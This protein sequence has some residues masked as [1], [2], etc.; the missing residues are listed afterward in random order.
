MPSFLMPFAIFLELS[1][2][3]QAKQWQREASRWKREGDEA[4]L[5]SPSFDAERRGTHCLRYPEPDFDDR[6]STPSGNHT[7]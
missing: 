2:G 4:L 3:R 7:P 5:F 1:Y 6:K